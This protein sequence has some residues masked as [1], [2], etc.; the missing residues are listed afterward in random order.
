MTL[1][2]PQYKTLCPEKRWDLQNLGVR[3]EELRLEGMSAAA[4]PAPAQD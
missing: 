2:G 1:E 4:A 3:V